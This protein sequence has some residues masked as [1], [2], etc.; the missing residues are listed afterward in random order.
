ML[1]SVTKCYRLLQSATVLQSI[2]EYCR[3]LQSI[4]ECY[5]ELQS[6]AECYRVL[7]NVAER[8]RVLQSVTEYYRILQSIS[9]ASTWT[10]FWAC[11]YWAPY[12]IVY[13]PKTSSQI[14]VLIYQIPNFRIWQKISTHPG[15]GYRR[16]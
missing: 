7:E 16:S 6:I 1:E 8:Y 10:N 2:A 3:V 5:R 9:S 15:R 14:Q 4:T 12:P 11:S 13:A